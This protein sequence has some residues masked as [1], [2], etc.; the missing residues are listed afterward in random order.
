MRAELERALSE[1]AIPCSQQILDK[2]CRYYELLIDWNQHTNLTALTAPLDF[3]YK[4]VLDSVLPVRFLALGNSALVDVGTGAGFPGLPLK[5]ISPEIQLFL[6][7]AS[8]KRV[9]FLRHCCARLEVDGKVV[10]ARAEELGRGSY[11]EFFDLAV[12]R[13]VASLPVIS[14]YCLP[15][16]RPGGLFA[17]LKGPGGK[18]EA[19]AAGTAVSLLGGE[20]RAV[21]RYRL[22]QGDERSLVLVDKVSPSPRRY[23]RRP[24][25][26]AKKPL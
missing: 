20:L 26:P 12:T 16:L 24:G 6:V 4:H 5:L 18:E 19:E 23:P 8:R 17:A 2:F 21:H 7:D 1:A 13:A 15:L 22:P 11:R 25:I 14:E 3:V 10:H 9:D